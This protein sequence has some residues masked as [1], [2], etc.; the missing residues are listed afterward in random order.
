MSLP[1]FQNWGA[2]VK[3]MLPEDRTHTATLLLLW[4]GP[5][6][7]SAYLSLQGTRA[8]LAQ[9]W[10][11]QTLKRNLTSLRIP[12]FFLEQKNYCYSKKTSFQMMR[13]YQYSTC[14][15][16]CRGNECVI[17]QIHLS[18]WTKIWLQ[19]HWKIKEYYANER[20][21]WLLHF[22]K[23]FIYGGFVYVSKK[24]LFRLYFVFPATQKALRKQPPMW[25]MRLSYSPINI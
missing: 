4:Q 7:V 14:E 8:F 24:L 17:I 2:G 15:K 18:L 22:H 16:V 20:K 10:Q 5:W 21:V 1:K 25:P 11:F 19:W 6:N 12:T 23:S 9:S 3:T 13:R